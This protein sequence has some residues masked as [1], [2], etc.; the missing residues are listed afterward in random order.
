MSAPS[1]R[2]WAAVGVGG[3]NAVCECEAFHV[4]WRGGAAE[5]L[6]YHAE[7]SHGHA[8]ACEVAVLVFERRL[9]QQIFVFERGRSRGFIA[10]V[11][12][13]HGEVVVAVYLR[14]ALRP[15]RLQSWLPGV[16]AS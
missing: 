5:I 10:H 4:A 3:R 13:K 8:F 11:G 9:A 6:V 7:D 14:E 2:S 1:A 15:I 16:V 12:G